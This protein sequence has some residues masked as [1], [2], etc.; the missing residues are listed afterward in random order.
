MRKRAALAKDMGLSLKSGCPTWIR[1]MTKASKGLC[2]TI[3][4]SDSRLISLRNMSFAL[5]TVSKSVSKM[6]QLTTP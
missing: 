5:L 1:T 2:A 4:P 6:R 3:T